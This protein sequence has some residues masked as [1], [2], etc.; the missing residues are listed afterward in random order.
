MGYLK[1]DTNTN[2]NNNNCNHISIGDVLT[3]AFVVVKTL[4]FKCVITFHTGGGKYNI[5][6]IE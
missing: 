5:F 3:E 1:Y 2:N 4:G 6:N